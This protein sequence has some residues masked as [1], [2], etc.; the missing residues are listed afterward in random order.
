MIRPIGF[1][2][3][4]VVAGFSILFLSSCGL[5]SDNLSK[6]EE[7]QDRRDLYETYSPLTGLYE[8]KLENSSSGA[9]PY[10]IELQVYLVE[11]QNGVNEDGEVRFRPTL[12]ARYKRLD[13]FSDGIGERTLVLRF[14]K[15][16]GELT[17]VSSTTGNASGGLPESNYLSFNGRFS[18]DRIEGEFKDHRGIVGKVVLNRVTEL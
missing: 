9:D 15:E 16:T 17:G 1:M 6:K 12:K 3:S 10:L 4:A 14:Y 13:F 18:K 5:E 7:L 11:E 8:G 2:T